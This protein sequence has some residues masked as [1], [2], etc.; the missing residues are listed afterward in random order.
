MD[1]ISSFVWKVVESTVTSTNT[2]GSERHAAESSDIMM[3]W[4]AIL[5]AMAALVTLIYVAKHV[6]TTFTGVAFS[7]F[8]FVVFY[9]VMRM[10]EMRFLEPGA[11]LIQKLFMY[12]FHS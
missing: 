7:F 3:G 5:I 9:I 6:F 8:Q 2:Y 10:I 4:L 11:T 12:L 1:H